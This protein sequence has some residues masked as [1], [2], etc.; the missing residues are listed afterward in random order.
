MPWDNA[1]VL[2]GTTKKIRLLEKNSLPENFPVDCFDSGSRVRRT[3]A[4]NRR[5]RSVDIS[6]NESDDGDSR[7]GV[8]MPCQTGVYGSATRENNLSAAEQLIQRNDVHVRFPG[9]VA[10]A[11]Q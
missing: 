9:A 2:C 3:E 11:G 1:G 5:R 8:K 10:A 4:E 7:P 6:A